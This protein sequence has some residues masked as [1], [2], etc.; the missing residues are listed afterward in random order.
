MQPSTMGHWLVVARAWQTN[1]SS[2]L[3]H[4]SV[5]RCNAGP[6]LRRAWWCC[7]AALWHKACYSCKPCGRAESNTYQ[8][9]KHHSA[10]GCTLSRTA[11]DYT[12]Y[13]KAQ[14]WGKHDDTALGTWRKPALSQGWWG[15]G[16]AQQRPASLHA[17]SSP[18]SSSSAP[19]SSF[20]AA[21]LGCCLGVCS[22]VSRNCCTSAALC[23]WRSC[24]MSAS[25]AE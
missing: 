16:A 15:G 18:A 10:A 4:S 7:I 6:I 8:A 13:C 20:C 19:A 17:D 12:R 23:S 22:S 2:R 14:L 11:N 24:D 3:S 5:S 21:R 1:H 25:S 9:Y